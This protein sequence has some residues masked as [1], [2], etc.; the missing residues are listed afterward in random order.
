M[1]DIIGV[2]QAL[3]SNAVAVAKYLLP[4]GVE[5]G[6][7]WRAGSIDGEKGRRL[8]VHLVGGRAGVWSDFST[9]EG[10]DLLDLWVKTRKVTL[11]EAICAARDWLGMARP[12]PISRPRGTLPPPPPP[13]STA[14]L[15]A[16]R[17]AR[18][19]PRGR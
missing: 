12:E 6:A 18:P 2:K 8:G 10:G 1:N 13:Q 9:G 17:G 3:A 11:S 19:P 4:R 5:G 7:E 16:P 14:P 15:R